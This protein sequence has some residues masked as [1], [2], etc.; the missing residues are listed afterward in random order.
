MDKLEDKS[1]NELLFEM[2]QL[3]A[4]HEALKIKMLK[5]LEKLEEIEDRYKKANGILLN[6]LK[7]N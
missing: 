1:N 7:V 4:E 3:E 2:K 5:D 6:R